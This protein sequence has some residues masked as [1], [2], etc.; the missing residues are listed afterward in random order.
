MQDDE[1]SFPPNL[2]PE[3]RVAA[4]VRLLTLDKQTE[5]HFLGHR[6]PGGVGRIFGGQVIAQALAAAECTV[7]DDLSP[8]SLHAYFMR[9]GNE[10][11]RIEFSVE[12]D[13][14]G[15]SFANRRVIAAQNGVPILNLLSSFQRKE[16]GLEHADPMPEGILP[17]EELELDS[18]SASHLES[19]VSDDQRRI[20]RNRAYDFRMPPE[21]W[22]PENEPQPMIYK[23]VRTVAPLPDDPKIHRAVIAYFSDLG[24]LSAGTARHGISLMQ[25]RVK[26]ASLDHAL[27]FHRDARADDWLC[28]VCE[29]PWTGNARG[30][31]L[32][33][34]YTR[35]GTLV[36]S[37]AQEGLIRVV[38]PAP[39]PE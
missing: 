16:S 38:K 8:H 36:A 37:M 14:D 10:D 23:W 19:N 1:E 39:I 26:G 32:G 34:F 7:G 5:N 18:A 6:K 30:F 35:D 22:L 33:R 4:L 2:D 11:Y 13:F 25:N 3:E 29:S 17:P 31:N 20:W 24:L 9:G 27:W 15:R 28:M 21:L 12:R